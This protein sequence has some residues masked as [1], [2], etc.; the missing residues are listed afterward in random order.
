LCTNLLPHLQSGVFFLFDVVFV[1]FACHN[2][3]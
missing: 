1:L 3:N 2:D